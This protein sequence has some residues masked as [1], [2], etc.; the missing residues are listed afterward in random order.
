VSPDNRYGFGYISFG[1][2][3]EAMKLWRGIGPDD[4]VIT[5]GFD[6]GEYSLN[7]ATIPRRTG[8][9]LHRVDGAVRPHRR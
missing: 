8:V 5:L 2:N 4:C 6:P 9:E 1:G 7:L 3:D